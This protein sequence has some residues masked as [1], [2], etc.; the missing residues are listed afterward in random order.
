MTSLATAEAK[1]S[2]SLYLSEAGD[3]G[4]VAMLKSRLSDGGSVLSY[5]SQEWVNRLKAYS[6][7][8]EQTP[9]FIVE[10]AT[11]QDVVEALTFAR[12]LN[13]PVTARNGAHNLAELSNVQGGVIISQSPRRGVTHN[14]E[15]GTV[16]YEGG[17]FFSNID[18]YLW[19]K[20]PGWCMQS[21]MIQSIG[22]TGSH[23]AV[24]VGWLQRLVGNGIDNLVRVRV[25]LADGTVA[26]A[27]ADENADLFFAL[28][29]AAPNYGIVT[30]VTER[31]HNIIDPN[32]G[33]E[34][35][36]GQYFFPLEHAETVMGKIVEMN[37]DPEFPDT[38]FLLPIFM[39]AN[40]QKGIMFWYVNYRFSNSAIDTSTTQWETA[41]RELAAESDGQPMN[42]YA[43]EGDG[44]LS[45]THMQLQLL[46][47][48]PWCA[49][50]YPCGG[51]VAR[52]K[53]QTCIQQVIDHWRKPTPEGAENVPFFTTAFYHFG[54]KAQ[55]QREPTAW[56]GNEETN[57]LCATWGGWLTDQPYV[58]RALRKAQTIQWV[59]AM[60]KNLRHDFQFGYICAA[61]F[62][63]RSANF[64]K[65]LHGPSFE[66]LCDIKEKFDPE[67]I[68]K[69]NVNIPPKSK[70]AYF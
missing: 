14:L 65:W 39:F 44:W 1:H 46:F 17:C 66:R 35:R 31:I 6:P 45:I 2:S 53:A 56:A 12:T 49:A 29:G 19:E 69:N 28:R 27:S 55:R 38:A 54:G 26:T 50:Y 67:N 21:A 60:H 20:A 64:A 11:E 15:E 43:P 4:A 62:N 61:A 23:F 70:C 47:A 24:G 42:H 7:Q 59:D 30:E 58:Q 52:D 34:V 25:V 32:Q 40:G 16:T 68:F 33:N 3:D 63:W 57:W 48:P 37:N 51:F 36:Y 41:V 13:L 10:C 5:G 8:G 18:E 9:A 22:T